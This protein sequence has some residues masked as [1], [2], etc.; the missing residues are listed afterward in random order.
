MTATTLAPPAPAAPAPAAR[1]RDPR[2]VRPALFGLLGAT[3]LLYLWG[4]GASGYANTFYSAAV[5]AGATSWKAFLFGS[6]DGA[7]SIMVDK[8]PASLWVVELS[9]RIFGV[10]P[11]SILVPQAL[12]G[13]ATVGVL[14]AAVRRWHGPT[15]GLLAGAM[16]ALTP[17][18]V[19]MFRFN[20][21]DALLVMLL[22]L[23]AYALIR[24]M[25]AG[26]TGWL[27]A[28]AA[29]VG[30]GFLTKMMQAFL[31]VPG[32][33]LAYLVAAPV[34][35]RRR[36]GQLLLAG[37]ALVASSGWWVA[38]VELWPAPDR[39]YVG[40]SQTNSILELI[41]GYN[42]FGRLTGNEIGSV[43][44]GKRP[45]GPGGGGGMFGGEGARG[46][47]D[48]A[49]GSQ[50]SWLLPAALLFLLTLL[51][52]GRRMP[53]TDRLRASMLLWGG[54][55][56]VTGTVLSYAQGIIHPYYTVA[57]A[58]AIGALV[59]I[60][61]VTLWP[62]RSMLLARVVLAAGLA[63]T[64]MWAYMLLDRAPSWQPW[65]RV[66]V[67]I[68]GL[69]CATAL[70]VPVRSRSRTG[71]VVAAVAIAL[72]LAAPAAYAL[73]TAATPHRGAIPSA[74]PQGGGFG[75]RGP[76]GR[77]GAF[78]G[79]G[80]PGP[81]FP[82]GRLPADGVPAGS[83]PGG[84]R[85]GS[86]GI[87]GLLNGTTSNTALNTLLTH[88]ADRYTWVAA[89]IGSNTAAGYQLAAG[90]P[91]MPIGGFNGSDPS[92][93]LAQFQQYVAHGK[94]HYFIGGGGFPGQNGGSSTSRQIATWVQQ[95][96]TPTTAGGTMV[97]DLTAAR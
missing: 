97:Y 42:G 84:R 18:A 32:F 7:N 20:N 27:V 44:G 26:R 1:R 87:G 33:A 11:W 29:F 10:N 28:A 51:W 58:P 30:L 45:G 61:A 74:G 76:G 53:R 90:H 25:E 15:A 56:L 91:V 5:Q 39:P 86:G 12:E 72:G 36:I 23:S 83:P 52:L 69:A 38:L 16:L 79:R 24:A 94:I 31:V 88:N 13:V 68:G 82:A 21:P 89:A 73:D 41:F 8:P 17:V 75:G 80:F 40:G 70:A 9:A 92:P 48:W 64:A 71:L 22:T 47:F 46:L 96:F 81:G 67:L 63:G 43:G 95:N 54:W 78:P 60:G 93:T 3:A 49:M 4:L 34:A 55:L 6:S 77:P 50:I 37:V 85:G 19:L 57:L 65:L 66:V 14:Y 35:L 62:L 59:G 2:W